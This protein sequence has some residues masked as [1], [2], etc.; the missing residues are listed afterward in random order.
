MKIHI[1]VVVDIFVAPVLVLLVFVASAIAPSLLK[2]RHMTRKLLLAVAPVDGVV[3]TA[4]PHHERVA[5]RQVG[6][7]GRN[8]AVE[9]T[10]AFLARVEIGDGCEQSA[11]VEDVVFSRLHWEVG[12]DRVNE[13]PPSPTNFFL[14]RGLRNLHLFCSGSRRRRRVRHSL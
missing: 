12:G 10:S 11:G 9:V 1:I 14:R 2:V 13:S 5:R 8:V 7:G 3:R 6:R 4:R